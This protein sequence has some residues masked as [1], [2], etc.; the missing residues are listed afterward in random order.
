MTDSPPIRPRSCWFSPPRQPSANLLTFCLP[1]AGG[2]AS[3]FKNWQP[4][5]QGLTDV[6]PILLPAREARFR[7]PP[8]RRMQPLVDAIVD[9]LQPNLDRPFALFGHSMG[10]LI[11]FEVA[12][13]LERMV[14][15]RQKELVCLFVSGSRPPHATWSDAG[16][17]TLPDADFLACL[18]DRYHAIPDVVRDNPELAQIVLP[19][20]RADFELLE[21]Y[22][23]EDTS[24]LVCPI[25]AYGGARDSTVTADELGTWCRY[26]TAPFRSR[27]FPGDHFFLRT[28]E[29]DLLADLAAQLTTPP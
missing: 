11:A 25:V 9:A 28:A 8:Y 29:S 20:L 15:T 26:T 6:C 3:N 14:G 21:T 24:P 27:L 19:A 10:A 13:K 18:H 4:R 7:D 2:G 17:Y 12:R 1:Y 22:R 16:I 5:L 23:C